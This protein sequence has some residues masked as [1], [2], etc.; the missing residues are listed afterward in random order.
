MH[1]P[2]NAQPP[3]VA[4]RAHAVDDG[5]LNNIWNRVD[6]DPDVRV[7]VLTAT[8]CGTCSACIDLQ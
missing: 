4:Q 1:G 3:R 2:R 6:A 7:I 8:Q 5:M